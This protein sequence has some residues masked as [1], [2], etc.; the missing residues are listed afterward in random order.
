MNGYDGGKMNV[1]YLY[2]TD[3]E[4]GDMLE[5]R[6]EEV[7]DYLNPQNVNVLFSASRNQYKCLPLWQKTFKKHRD[8]F[9]DLVHG[10]N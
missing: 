10:M 4:A 7:F 9:L 8:G 6:K 5:D 3:K 2:A 1:T